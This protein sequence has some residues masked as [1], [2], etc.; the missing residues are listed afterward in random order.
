MSPNISLV[1]PVSGSITQNFGENAIDYSQWGYPGHNGVDFGIPNGTPVQAAAAG[2]VEKVGFENGGYGN[3]VKIDHGGGISTYYAHLQ[4]AAVAAGNKVQAG[5]VIA[6]SN[7]TGASTGPHLHFGL[8]I[9]GQN[10]A[11][12]GYV[13][14]LP[15]LT[16]VTPGPG[17]GPT[18]G[19]GPG[20]TPGPG[21]G[22][23]PGPGPGPGPVPVPPEVWPDAFEFKRPFKVI[24]DVNLRSGPGT[25]YPLLGQLHEGD[26][27]TINRLLLRD[28]WVEIEPGKW[29]AWGYQGFIYLQLA[30]AQ[31]AGPSRAT[32]FAPPSQPPAAPP[33]PSE[34]KEKEKGKKK[35]K[36]GKKKK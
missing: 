18:P 23:T 14:P 7:N 34:K 13:D 1:W 32:P 36:K 10:P 31:V 19:P 17:P 11:Y 29:A 12:K 22:P 4:G 16:G 2:T 3:Y 26:E 35:K 15:Y 33:A 27:I 5:Q 6:W 9:I 21:P 20:P 28:A 30:A 8:R 24:G 25:N